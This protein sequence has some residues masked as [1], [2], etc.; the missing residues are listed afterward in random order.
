MS[1]HAA[2]RATATARTFRVTATYLTLAALIVFFGLIVLGAGGR[3]TGYWAVTVQTAAGVL[4]IVGVA[5]AG[6]GLLFE[7]GGRR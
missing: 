7:H 2:P 6:V 1:R 5:A 3:L 4:A